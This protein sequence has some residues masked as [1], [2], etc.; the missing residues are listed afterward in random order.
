[1]QIS[2]FVVKVLPPKLIWFGYLI[3]VAL[4]LS[5]NL[6]ASPVLP[7]IIFFLQTILGENPLAI[8]VTC[9]EE[10]GVKVQLA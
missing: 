1:M 6:L 2:V 8:E 7:S 3:P 5:L 9:S 10:R 4:Q